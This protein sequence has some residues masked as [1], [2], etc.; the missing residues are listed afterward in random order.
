MVI[1]E[2]KGQEERDIIKALRRFRRKVD[3]ANIIRDVLD[4]RYY[5]KPSARRHRDRNSTKRRKR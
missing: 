2:V 4:H 5:L 1:V 3:K